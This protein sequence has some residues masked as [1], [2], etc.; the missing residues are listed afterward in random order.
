[1]DAKHFISSLLSEEEPLP[2]VDSA[3]PLD[4]VADPGAEAPPADGEPLDP[5]VNPNVEALV[6]TWQTGNH[7]AV[8]LRVLDALDSYEDFVDLLYRIGATDAK[9]LG[10][11]M[12]DLTKN[13]ESPHEFDQVP[14]SDVGAGGP[15]A[16][17][18]EPESRPSIHLA[19]GESEEPERFE[20]VAAVLT[21]KEAG[22]GKWARML[23]KMKSRRGE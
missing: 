9:E 3:A 7:N 14:D 2:P 15:P 1:M 16:A 23:A 11:I 22:D 8:A 13:E 19:H 18:P 12:D 4:P 17:A 5:T 10:R 21:E 6:N 20:D